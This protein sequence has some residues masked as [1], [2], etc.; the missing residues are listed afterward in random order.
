MQSLVVDAQVLTHLCKVC[1]GKIAHLLSL[2]NCCQVKIIVLLS[3]HESNLG[4]LYCHEDILHILQFFQ[5]LN[6]RGNFSLYFG[7]LLLRRHLDVVMI[8][9][10]S[11]QTSTAAATPVARLEVVLGLKFIKI[12][13]CDSFVGAIIGSLTQILALLLLKLRVK[14]IIRVE[15]RVETWII[16]IGLGYKRPTVIAVRLLLLLVKFAMLSSSPVAS[17]TTRSALFYEAGVAWLSVLIASSGRRRQRAP[18][19]RRNNSSSSILL[20]LSNAN[21]WNRSISFLWWW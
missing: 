17:L 18:R 3:D 1:K 21:L 14:V 10:L 9:L 8:T 12:V 7:V 2:M 19:R 15:I 5:G 20:R 13:I 4:L 6:F 11:G 16:T